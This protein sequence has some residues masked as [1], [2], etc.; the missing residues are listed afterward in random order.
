MKP[1]K[2]KYLLLYCI[3]LLPATRSEERGGGNK[4]PLKKFA[5]AW[6]AGA[7]NV[8]CTS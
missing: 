6:G 7:G 3:E 8:L 1:N 4:D 5:Q 2:S